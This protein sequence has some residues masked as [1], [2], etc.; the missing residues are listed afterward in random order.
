MEEVPAIWV[1]RAG[2]K[3]TVTQNFSRQSKATASV[4]IEV[5]LYSWPVQV[6]P[7][8]ESAWFQQPLSL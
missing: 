3:A 6:E 1:D 7:Q 8:L 4:V 2:A 5:G